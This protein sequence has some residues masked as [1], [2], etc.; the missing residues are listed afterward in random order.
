MR[1][2]IR[3]KRSAEQSYDPDRLDGGFDAE[4]KRLRAQVDMSWKVERRRLAALGVMDGHRL[5]ELGCGPGFVTER[6]ASA[7][8][9][10]TI[11]AIDTDQKM[12][13][14]AARNT[15][16]VDANRVE[17]VRADVTATGLE[18]DFFDGAIS[19]YLFQ[20]LSDPVAAAVETL[21]VLKPGGY[22][23]V[24]DIDDGLWGLV[25]PEFLFFRDYHKRRGQDQ[26]SRGGSRFLGRRLGRILRAA[27][28]VHIDLDIFAYH[29]DDVGMEAFASQIAPEQFLPL[30]RQGDL[31]LVEYIRAVAAT[32]CFLASK[33]SF[34]MM[35]GFIARGEK[36]Q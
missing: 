6:L 36:P 28:Y 5:L 10:A 18:A 12:L 22:H 30:V 35:T 9:H 31:S 17:F 34:L 2:D 21:R 24:I 16:N 26:S 3:S 25:E 14:A 13:D 19:R 8:P 32:Q 29:S 33:E 15:T 20:H 23:V 4:L 7:F 11:V 1:S 27:G